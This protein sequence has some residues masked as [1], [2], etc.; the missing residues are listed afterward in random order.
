MLSA[1][2]RPLL[3]CPLPLPPAYSHTSCTLPTCRQRVCQPAPQFPHKVV[4][5]NVTLETIALPIDLWDA[6]RKIYVPQ[7]LIVGHALTDEEF[8]PMTHGAKVLRSDVRSRQ[9]ET[10]APAAFS[11]DLPP[12]Y[13]AG[14]CVAAHAQELAQQDLRCENAARLAHNLHKKIDVSR[15]SC[16]CTALWTNSS[17]ST[18]STRPPHPLEAASST[19]RGQVRAGALRAPVASV[20]H[21]PLPPCAHTLPG[22]ASR[23]PRPPITTTS[24]TTAL[25]CRR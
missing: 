13:L 16:L 5:R 1:S 3:V 7:G 20:P 12:V 8:G 4:G 14:T 2:V 21:T 25:P 9:R 6:E 17:W 10:K 11:A 22:T 23:P 18:A 19:L 24:T 15:Q